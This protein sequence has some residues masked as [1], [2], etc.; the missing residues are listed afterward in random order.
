MKTHFVGGALMCISTLFLS[1]VSAQNHGEHDHHEQQ[2]TSEVTKKAAQVV[3]SA[4]HLSTAQLAL[5]NISVTSI[6][7]RKMNVT[8]YAPAELK[9]NGYTSYLV[10][11]RVD[12]VVIKRHVSLGQHVQK[13]QALVTLFSEVIAQAQAEY[14]ID[15]A[16]WNRVKSLSRTTVSEKQQSESQTRYIAA[17]ANLK[18]FGLTPYAIDMLV[19]DNSSALGEYTLEAEQSG[20]VLNDDFQQGQRVQA[21]EAL[22]TLADESELWVEAR[23]SP[24][25]TIGLP[26]G[27]TALLKVGDAS[28]QAQVIQEAHTIDP[29]TRTRIVRLSVENR[30]HRLHPGMFGDVF[31][32]FKTEN[33]VLAVPESALMRSDDGDWIVFVE[34]RPGEFQA[35]EVERRRSLGDLREIVGVV[36]GVNVVTKGAFFV[37]SEQAKSGFD[38]HNH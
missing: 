6:M 20:S 15:F 12:S 32:S 38:P 23:L 35:V 27:S 8:L 13:G 3:P 36:A 4:I 2:K 9:A 17:L 31:F 29:Q 5:A 26:V 19:K 18:A 28:Y 25:D 1:P 37:A 7:P 34:A 16:E 33:T 24:N 10:S 11:P 30:Y 14:R 21:G 22:M